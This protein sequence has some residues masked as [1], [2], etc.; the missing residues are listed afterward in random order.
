MTMTNPLTP[1]R[2]GTEDIGIDIAKTITNGEQLAIKITGIRPGEKLHEQMI[3]IE[4]APNTFEYDDYYK[5]LPQIHEWA[6]DPYR[7][8]NGIKV[9]DNFSFTSDNN[10][11]WMMRSE[12]GIW[13]GKNQKDFL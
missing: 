2:R 8:K 12:L 4:D 10:R 5:I 11:C 13:I 9:G 6:K 1:E 3:G 7:I